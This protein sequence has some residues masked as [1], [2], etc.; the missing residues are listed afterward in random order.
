MSH[1]GEVRPDFS[2]PLTS[3]ASR[4][5]V[6]L[7]AL[8]G[9]CYRDQDRKELKPVQDALSQ[10]FYVNPQNGKKVYRVNA[11]SQAQLLL[12]GAWEEEHWQ[13]DSNLAKQFASTPNASVAIIGQNDQRILFFDE[14]NHL[15]GV[16]PTAG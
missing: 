9:V 6:E 8:F 10:G 2:G 5:D 13:P 7:L 11:I 15:I 3:K 14:Q 12:Q 1:Y 4:E 16:F